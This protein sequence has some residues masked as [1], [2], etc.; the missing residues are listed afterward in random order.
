MFAFLYKEPPFQVRGLFFTFI[1]ATHAIIMYVLVV[2]YIK[3]MY[4]PLQVKNKLHDEDS[5]LAFFLGSMFC[6][7]MNITN[8]QAQNYFYSCAGL[9]Q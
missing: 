5:K 3:K 7:V 4:S 8:S 2:L 9:K 6:R 1:N